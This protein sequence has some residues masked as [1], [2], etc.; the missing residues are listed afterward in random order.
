M[1]ITFLFSKHIEWD[2][3][4]IDDEVNLIVE[5]MRLMSHEFPVVQCK[6]RKLR[7]IFVSISNYLKFEDLDSGVRLNY[8]DLNAFDKRV[9]DAALDSW[10]GKSTQLS[11]S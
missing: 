5:S 6:Y 8:F 10:L 3:C 1:N 2:R 9:V 7:L 11:S 4:Y